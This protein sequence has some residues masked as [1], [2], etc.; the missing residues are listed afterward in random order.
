[1]SEDSDSS[2]FARPDGTAGSFEQRPPGADR[3]PTT[4]P[5]P[6]SP[7]DRA[8]FGNPPGAPGTQVPFAPAPGD[9]LPP[10]HT[11][12][13]HP[14]PR[15]VVDS[16]AG[17]GSGEPFE[18]PPEARMTAT[19]PGPGSPWWK[20]GAATDPWRDP[21]SPYWIAGPP[22]FDGTDLVGF[23]ELPGDDEQPSTEST[24]RSGLR[25]RFGLSALAIVLVAGLVAGVVGG[26]VGWWIAQR[27]H[28]TL[29]DPNVKL[30]QVEQPVSRPVGSVAEIAHRVSPAVVSIDVRTADVA[31]SGSGVII[32]KNGYILTNNHVVSFGADKPTI[33]VV[34]ADK[35]SAPGNVVG[36]DPQNDLAVIKVNKSTLTVATL[37]DSD[38]LAVGDPVIAIGDPL[39][40]RGTVT[41]GIVSALKRPLRLSGENGNPDAVI[42]AIQTDAPINPGNSGGALVDGSGAVVGVNTAILSLGQ[43]ASG[44]QGGSIG[45]GFAIPIN[46]A[47]NV[48]QQLIR[49][50]KV[51]HASLGVSSRGVTDGT[52]DGA[53]LVQ[54]VPG[55]PADKAGLKAGD[56]VTLFDTT[57]IDSGDALTVA[58]A[59]SAPGAVVTIH[60]V[61]N[62]VAAQTKAT[63]GSG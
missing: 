2:A 43:A 9:R 21:L 30:A 58:V 26:G 18:P 27:A 8:L 36:T 57:L 29:T 20:E 15:H 34:F 13:Q 62:G 39:G 32:D 49:T 37:G 59:E 14:V 6:V 24:D 50:G 3:L 1:V 33:R 7:A 25:R 45:V 48:A 63:L 12:M 61:R 47:R 17:E 5:P 16:Y 40:L 28:N 38:R 22:V 46:T 4:P 19:L 44:G 11:S 42:D 41:A 56:V 52:R 31:G 54:I 55:G 51:V 23:G 10:R 35:S 53:Y 60:Y